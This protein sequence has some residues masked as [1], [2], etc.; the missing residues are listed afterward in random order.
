MQDEI[1][2]HDRMILERLIQNGRLQVTDMASEVGLSRTAIAQRM[3]KLEKRGTIRGYTA[4]VKDYPDEKSI[5]AFIA[6]RHPGLL[7]G[8]AEK[9]VYALSKRREILEIHGVAG[10]D[11]VYVKV[12]V[13]DM[14]ELSEL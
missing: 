8:K 9:A 1:D 7:Q 12:R 3:E 14:H 11:C 2:K 5:T 4:V 13:K 10:E 6:A